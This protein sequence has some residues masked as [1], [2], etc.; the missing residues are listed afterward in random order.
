MEY[1]RILVLDAGKVCT[2]STR[3]V[4]RAEDAPLKIAEFD[5]PEN[6]LANSG[7]MFYSLAAEAGLI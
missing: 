4:Q 3:T 1:D 5:T 6:L 2:V 7:S